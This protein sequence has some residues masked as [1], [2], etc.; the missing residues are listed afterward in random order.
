M[1]GKY[2][3]LFNRN[4]LVGIALQMHTN[5]RADLEIP[6]FKM[7]TAGHLLNIYFDLIC[8]VFFTICFKTTY[9]LSIF[10]SAV[11]VPIT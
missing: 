3:Y 7:Q 10:R 11:E 9:E 4:V 8:K 2:H 6:T 5:V 1:A